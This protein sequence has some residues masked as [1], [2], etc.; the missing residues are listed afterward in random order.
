LLGAL[1]GRGEY[2]VN[3]FVGQGVSQDVGAGV[4]DRGERRVIVVVQAFGVA[5]EVVRRGAGGPEEQGG[6]ERS[7]KQFH[8]RV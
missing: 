4:T 6:K 5:Y 3:A 7:E 1:D 8:I 2:L